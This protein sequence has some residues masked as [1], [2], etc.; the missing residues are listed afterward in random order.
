MTGFL[1]RR[2]FR[3]QED[4]SASGAGVCLRLLRRLHSTAKDNNAT[5]A[6]ACLP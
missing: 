1:L 5:G 3:T 4:R 6:G 2:S